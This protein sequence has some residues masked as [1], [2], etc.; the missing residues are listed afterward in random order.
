MKPLAVFPVALLLFFGVWCRG[1]VA[2]SANAPVSP[3]LVFAPAVRPGPAMDAG[4]SPAVTTI[5]TRG[6]AI[7]PG[8]TARSLT[9]EQ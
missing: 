6:L 9:A 5:L 2:K 3:A 8:Q 1:D 7:G 4:S